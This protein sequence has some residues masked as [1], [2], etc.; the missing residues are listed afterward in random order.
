M[1]KSSASFRILGV[2]LL[3][4]LTIGSANAQPP[5]FELEEA[6]IAGIHAAYKNGT[7]TAHQLVERYLARSATYDQQGPKLNSIILAN[8]RVLAEADALDAE[9]RKTKKLRPLHGIPVLLKDNVETEGLQ[10]TAGSLS[11]KGYVPSKDA[12]L[13]KKLKDAG[14]I[15]IAKTNLHEFAVWGETVS[16]MAGQTLNPYDLTRTPG[17]SSGGTGAAVA[18]NFGTVGIGSDTVNSI[19][20]PASANSLVGIRPTLGLVSRTGVV[21]YS[22]TQDTA[23]PITRTV[24]DA[25]RVLDV[26]AGY[27]SQ[28]AATAAGVGQ[29]PGTYTAFLDKDGL[30]SARIGI[31]KSFFGTGPEHQETNAVIERA[32]DTMRRRGAILVVLADPIDANTLSSKTSVHLHDLERDLDAYLKQ[33]PASVGVHSLKEVIASGKYHKGIEDNIKQA[34]T[35]DTRSVDYKDRLIARQALQSQ[36]LRIMAD[37]RL[38][39]ILFPHQKRLVVPVGQTQVERNGVLGSVSGFPSIVLPAGFSAPTATAPIGV[40]VGVELLG[41][42]F[43][44]PVLIRL[45]YAFEQSTQVRKPPLSAPALR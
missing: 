41:R 20:S 29:Q 38:D 6:T 44:E 45:G 8:P 14:A 40:P 39:A 28:D 26:I 7:I 30:K 12:F 33:L 32:V 22:L 25:A 9:F 4:S 3:S 10:T 18:A 23:G 17:G 19:R 2:S 27:D 36:V 13:A 5:S 16:S 31:L 35:L 11:L 34:V 42:P 37:N 24:A 15:V 1:K 21:P 43:A